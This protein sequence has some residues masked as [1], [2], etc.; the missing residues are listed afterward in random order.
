MRS[1][2]VN[3]QVYFSSLVTAHEFIACAGSY[4]PGGHQG[5]Q[6]MELVNELAVFANVTGWQENELAA[7]MDSLSIFCS[8]EFLKEFDQC[9]RM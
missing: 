8:H 6:G 4:Q 9:C 1:C 2:Q 3:K 7:M 5:S